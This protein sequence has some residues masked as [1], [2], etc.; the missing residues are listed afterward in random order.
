M[1]SGVSYR[2]VQSR[3][4]RAAILFA[5]ASGVLAIA[6]RTLA[7]TPT[8]RAAMNTALCPNWASTP[9]DRLA[10]DSYLVQT[11]PVSERTINDEIFD[12]GASRAIRNDYEN[13]VASEDAR[14]N[15]GLGNQ[16]A[17][18]KTRFSALHDYA[19]RAFD[20]MSKIRLKLEGDKLAKLAKNSDLPPEPVGAVVLAASL[21]T[22][23]SMAFRV[24]GGTRVESRVVAKDKVAEV[25]AP[26]GSLGTRAT[27][28]YNHAGEVCA[29]D[30]GCALLSQPI[31][32]NVSAVL[33]S[34]EKG[35]ARLIYSV[36]F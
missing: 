9:H 32:T 30:N 3:L 34:A 36:S 27:L 8:S 33:N 13:Y 20:T 28:A 7:S 2:I 26:I 21:Y 24:F 19:K 25:T 17:T 14:S 11:A 1:K 31:T 10:N 15:A 6:P 5:V 4:R 35:S 16:F 22:G 23:R 12:P 29:G 18:E